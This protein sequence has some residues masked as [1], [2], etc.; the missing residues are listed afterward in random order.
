MEAAT[1]QFHP[2]HS[3]WSLVAQSIACKRETEGGM[4]CPLMGL[5][6]PNLDCESLSFTSLRTSFDVI[7]SL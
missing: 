3:P 4:A 7:R 6:T 1:R 2:L 5:T